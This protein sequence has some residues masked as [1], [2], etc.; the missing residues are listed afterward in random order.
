MLKKQ[1]GS[2][3]LIIL[4]IAALLLLSSC[5][6]GASDEGQTA[7]VASTYNSASEDSLK[8]IFME[9][10]KG[11][12]A[13]ISIPGGYWVMIDTGPKD[14]FAEVGRQLMLNHVSNLSAIFITHEHADHIGGLESVLNLAGC[15]KIYTTPETLKGKKIQKAQEA[16]VQSEAMGVKQI[17]R[18]GEAT[19]TSLGPIGNYSDEN[20]RSLVL[21]L[22]YKDKKILFAADQLFAAESDLL[23]E[24]TELNAD[25]LKVARHGAS[26]SSS[27]EFIN[28]VSPKYAIIPTD[29]GNRPAQ[30]V[31]DI[32]SRT[33][34]ETF[35]LGDTG[36]LVYNSQMDIIETLPIST[37]AL[38]DIRVEAKDISAEAITIVNH[39]AQ[40]VDL[41]G[42]CI[43]SAKGSDTYFF[44]EGTKVQPDGILKIYSGDAAK[45]KN[46]GLIWSTKNI[47]SDKKEDVCI[48]FDQFGRQVSSL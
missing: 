23:T 33:G 15:D 10:G 44:P 38:Q 29:K 27:T 3:R 26:D 13:L 6:S 39:S 16:G 24:G 17:V 30:Q 4:A 37:S 42:W 25:V 18:I 40:S 19:F 43:Y 12:A 11:D 21:M 31:V 35:V 14:G 47:W 34:A 32:I 5:N 36:T 20:D 9:V 41:T 1:S 22:E 46:D 45:S 2:I 48:L 7:P 8:V 28:A